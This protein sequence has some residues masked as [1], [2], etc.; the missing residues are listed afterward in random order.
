MFNFYSW[1]YDVM[2][3]STWRMLESYA[4]FRTV[5]TNKELL[6]SFVHNVN[7]RVESS[8]RIGTRYNLN[9]NAIWYSKWPKLYVNKYL[10]E[11]ISITNDDQRR[12]LVLI[13]FKIKVTF[14]IAE[15]RCSIFTAGH[16]VTTN[17]KWLQVKHLGEPISM[18]TDYALHLCHLSNTSVCTGCQ[19]VE[20]G[21]A[22]AACFQFENASF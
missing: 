15:L 6:N 10:G 13:Q 19:T 8:M 16:D 3:N 4:N 1:T 18:T 14:W 21:A 9:S 11:P 7:K 20:E 5:T 12:F 22:G 17:S 2:A